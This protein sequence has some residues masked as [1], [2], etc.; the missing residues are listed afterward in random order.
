MFSM[1]K[2]IFFHHPRVSNFVTSRFPTASD[3]KTV[4]KKRIPRT[5]KDPGYPFKNGGGI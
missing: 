2:M 1:H 5:A 3:F 4:A